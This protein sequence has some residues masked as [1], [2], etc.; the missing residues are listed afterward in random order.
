[1]KQLIY[2]GIIL[3]IF[4]MTGCRSVECK[5]PLKNETSKKWEKKLNHSKKHIV[6]YWVQLIKERNDWNFFSENSQEGLSGKD[7]ASIKLIPTPVYRV[8]SVDIYNLESFDTISK[9]LKLDTV[10][11][12]FY[13]CKKNEKIVAAIYSK[14][15]NGHWENG[16]GYIGIFTPIAKK[17]ERSLSHKVKIINIDVH[18]F[19]KGNQR[20]RYVGYYDCEKQD[21]MSIQ[22]NGDVIPLIDNLM[23]L[24]NRIYSKSRTR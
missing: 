20:F 12:T 8:D 1:M 19:P 22:S 3:S 9:I 18:T 7:I 2:S 4:L 14:F 16:R 24:K 17:I 15:V 11:A 21:F 23:E 6:K 13:V 5:F 10:N